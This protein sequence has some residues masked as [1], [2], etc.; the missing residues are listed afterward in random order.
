LTSTPTRRLPQGEIY[1]D[2]E[3]GFGAVLPEEWTAG[4]DGEKT[5]AA[6][7]EAVWLSDAPNDPLIIVVTGWLEE[8]FDGAL[9]KA[10]TPEEV[11]LVAGGSLGDEWDAR[12]KA[13]TEVDFKDYQA[14][15]G[16]IED[17]NPERLPQ[18][19]GRAVAVLLDGRAAMIWSLAPEDQWEEFEPTLNAFLNSI[20]FTEPTRPPATR[21]PTRQRRATSTRASGA[22]E[23]D[24][25]TAEPRPTIPR[26]PA[27]PTPTAVPQTFDFP[28]PEDLYV[29]DWE[30]YSILVPEGWRVYIEEG[31]FTVAPSVDDFSLDVIRSPM[32]EVTVGSLSSLWDG[33]AAGATGPQSLLDVAIQVQVERGLSVVGEPRSVQIAGNPALTVELTGQG[34]GGQLTSVYLGDN[35]AVLMGVLAPGEQW[36][37]FRP[38][39][40]AMSESLKFNV[41]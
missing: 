31:T 9:A 33:A 41:S 26:P 15:T 20:T 40:Q 11:I 29:N 19:T 28:L 30:N 10:T 14:V 8:I 1:Y 39:F 22:S 16:T 38:V 7:T 23:L 25:P 3:R 34:L 18:L 35:R 13:V 21:T 12:V 2:E 24:E 5:A 27:V 6:I 17:A 36:S 37:S 32:V 4:E